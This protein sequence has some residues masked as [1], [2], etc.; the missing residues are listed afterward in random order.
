MNIRSIILYLLLLTYSTLWSQYNILPKDV[1]LL[2]NA[3]E[4]IR[5]DERQLLIGTQQYS[6]FKVNKVVS[7]LSKSE[8]NYPIVIPYDTE[9]KIKNLSLTVYDATGRQ[10]RAYKLKDFQDRSAVS[11]FSIYEDSR[12]KYIDLRPVSTP[13]TYQ[14]EV[15]SQLSG[16]SYINY[17]NWQPQTFGQSLEKASYAIEMPANMIL[18]YKGLNGMPE[19]QLADVKQGKR[20]YWELNSLLST[21][22]EN[23]A[24]SAASLFP[25]LWV[26]ADQFTLQKVKGSMANWQEFGN[27]LHQLYEG[28]QQLS[29]ALKAKVQEIKAVSTTTEALV[30]NLFDYVAQNTRYVSVQLGIGGWQPFDVGY[31]EKNKYGDCKALSNFMMAL[32]REAGIESYLVITYLGDNPPELNEDFALSAFNHMILYVPTLDWWLD[33]TSKNRPY[34]YPGSANT[35]RKSLIVNGKNSRLQYIPPYEPQQPPISYTIHTEILNEKEILVKAAI[36]LEGEPQEPYRYLSRETKEAQRKAILKR[37]KFTPDELRAFELNCDDDVPVCTIHA[38][39]H[40]S[41]LLNKSGDVFFVPINPL[42]DNAFI[43]RD[44]KERQL[45]FVWNTNYD[46]HEVIRIQLPPNYTLDQQTLPDETQLQGD[47]GSFR[48]Q[49]RIEN[50]QLLIERQEQLRTGIFPADT[51]ADWRA[52]HVA[53]SKQENIS[54]SLKKR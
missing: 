27:F 40:Y 15:E 20:Y 10:I 4:I 5:L 25:V 1:A 53:I 33:C 2:Q 31:V 11:S 14:L 8:A 24:P 46:K 36:R 39:A 30:M 17:P 50:N 28:R 48:T 45:P 42:L 35:N 54:L 7:V 9:T 44:M 22:Y 43:P 47:F 52:F 12:L 23:Y 29:P 26:S 41:R 34:R 19:P 16:L 49:L 21:P 6:T 32:L 13:F 51:Y 3:A 37:W 18:H 38:E